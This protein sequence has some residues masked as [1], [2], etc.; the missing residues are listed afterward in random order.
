MEKIYIETSVISFLAARP[1]RDPVKLAKQ[2]LTRQWWETCN[3]DFDLHISIAVLDEIK[4]GDPNAVNRRMDMVAGLT[5][6]DTS[7]A[8]DSLLDQLLSARV[9]PES[10]V[11]DAFHIAMAAVHGMSVLLTWNCKHI[12]NAA[13]KGKITAILKNAGY[14]EVVIA[15]PEELGRNRNGR[16]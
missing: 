4:K 8:V 7:D 16:N 3:A 2:E 14:T 9:V 10:A 6:L 11:L 1:S 15:T 5:V 13:Q 12:N